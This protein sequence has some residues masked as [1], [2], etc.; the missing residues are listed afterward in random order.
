MLFM[1][2]EY[3]ETSPFLYFTSITDPQLVEAVRQG[4]RR[5]FADFAQGDNMP[6][7]FDADT[8]RRCF[9][10][11]ALLESQPNSLLRNF[12][13]KLISLR[14]SLPLIAQA[15]RENIRVLPFEADKALTIRYQSGLDT[16]YLALNFSSRPANLTMDLHT[17]PWEILLNST[18]KVWGGPGDHSSKNIVSEGRYL[19]EAPSY[20][21]TLLQPALG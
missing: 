8:V 15:T 11:L 3:G 1:G 13:R 6:D 20:S 19:F 16:A 2:E 10:D 17:G 14:K 5:E 9:L 18:D 21:A 7:P 4:R 12:Y